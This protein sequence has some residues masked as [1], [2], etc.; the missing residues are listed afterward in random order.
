MVWN[1]RPKSQGTIL[2]WS[3][4]LIWDDNMNWNSAKPQSFVL[5]YI[6]KFILRPTI[7][8]L[9]CSGI[10]PL[11]GTGDQFFFLFLRNYLQALV[12]PFNMGALSDERTGLLCTRTFAAGCHSRVQVSQYLRPY[13]TLLFETGFFLSLLKS[14]GLRWRESQPPPRG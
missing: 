8:R 9:V 11:S 4:K 1:I 6:V 2:L 7:S 12:V 10:R 3:S 14:V 5:V 13:L